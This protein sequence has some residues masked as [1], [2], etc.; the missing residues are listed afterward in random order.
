MGSLI[1][2][3]TIT[4][5]RA[6]ANAAVSVTISWQIIE[7]ISGVTVQRGITSV[8]NASTNV[9]IS[10]VDLTKSFAIVTLMS[11]GWASYNDYNYEECVKASLSSST[12]LNLAIQTR[13]FSQTVA[14]QVIEYDAC[15][16]QQIN[17]TIPSTSITSDLSISSIDPL[18]TF[19]CGS[20][21]TGEGVLS[22]RDMFNFYILN[23]TTIRFKRLNVV[24]SAQPWTVFVVQFDLNEAVV[25]NLN[26]TV[27]TNDTIIDVTIDSLNENK[28]FV[29]SNSI[30]N[31]FGSI[32]VNNDQL[33]TMCFTNLLLS[34]TQL[35]F[36]RVTSGF[37]GLLRYQIVEF[38]SPN[39]QWHLRG[40]NRGICVGM[41]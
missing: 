28:S 18:R 19:V 22:G 1:N 12:T 16:V 40:L 21:S 9:T 14:W 35:Q 2:S 32:D 25:R 29:S 3:T 38:L 26:T 6:V 27:N 17:Y 36:Q 8:N 5:R 7:F 24:A 30:Y 4:F 39:K 11:A 41:S 20:F 15:T 33:N 10:T 34:S 37:N 23:D 31:T 13:T